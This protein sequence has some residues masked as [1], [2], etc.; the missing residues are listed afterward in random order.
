M[1]QSKLSL[2][3]CVNFLEVD[4]DADEVEPLVSLCLSV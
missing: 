4:R 3:G 1:V 2:D